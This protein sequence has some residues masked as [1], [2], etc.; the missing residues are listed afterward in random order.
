M[1]GNNASCG[2]PSI[3]RT[4]ELDRATGEGILEFFCT[5][6]ASGL[7]IIVAM[8]DPDNIH[9]EPNE[10]D[11]FATGVVN[12]TNEEFTPVT[13]PVIQDDSFITQPIV[14]V[15]LAML[16]VIGAG[17]FAYY[18]LRGD[19]DFLPG[20]RGQSEGSAPEQGSGAATFRYDA[21]SGITYDAETGEVISEKKD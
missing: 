6:N 17:M 14:W 7:Y 1:W 4:R 20:T 12:V 15:P 19:D 2:D 5:P 11:N 13:P 8:V 16:A 21:E 18:R 9:D 10:D 3:Q